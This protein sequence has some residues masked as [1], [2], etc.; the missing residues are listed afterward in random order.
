MA[1][2]ADI[3]LISGGASVGAYD[4]G[5]RAL[6]GAGFEVHF[7]RVNLRPGKPLVFAT[8]GRQAAFVL[9]GNP[10]SHLVVLNCVV[11][12]A[13]ERMAGVAPELRV[14]NA[15]L[16]AGFTVGGD[17]RD[18][19]WPGRVDYEG[20]EAVVRGLRWK[21]SGDITGLAGL[22]AFIR[23]N[24]AALDTGAVAPCILTHG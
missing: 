23:C 7:G 4:F 20:G 19:L 1:G 22:N 11:G 15:R 16:R 9:P 12:V 17:G 6:E 18:T 8:R 5:R 13:F 3:V 21:S 10:L 2:E 14:M 24:A